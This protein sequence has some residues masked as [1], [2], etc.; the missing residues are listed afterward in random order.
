M[1]TIALDRKVA[2]ITV[3]LLCMCDVIGGGHA[4]IIV[5]YRIGNGGA[6]SS[7]KEVSSPFSKDWISFRWDGLSLSKNDIDNLQ[8]RL[9]AD[10]YASKFEGGVS[11]DTM[12][13]EVE[14]IPEKIGVFM[15]CSETGTQSIIN[16][17]KTVLAQKGYTKFFEYEDPGI[18]NV[19]P[20][21]EDYEFSSD[22]I[23]FYFYGHGEYK[24]NYDNSYW[25]YRPS[26][27]ISSEM[28]RYLMD[29]LE[30]DKKGFL[31]EACYSGGFVDDFQDEYYLA[32]SSSSKYLPSYAYGPGFPSEGIF[33]DY[34]WN[35]AGIGYNAID[36]FNLARTFNSLIWTWPWQDP[37]ITD[38]TV[39]YDFF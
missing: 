6:W 34:F 27:S 37:Q 29:T 39:G 32:M 12:Y 4:K 30:T 8:I 2:S 16:Q 21:I 7:E 1:N 20:D 13:V 9:T 23:F 22:T 15:W 28:L 11:V 36:A 14:H 35:F 25:Y 10:I 17:Y 26:V 24:S 18:Y 38:H 31:I 33:S 5:Y 19:F 3:H